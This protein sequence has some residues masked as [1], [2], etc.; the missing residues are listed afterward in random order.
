MI[1]VLTCDIRCQSRLDHTY[2]LPAKG[3]AF[4]LGSGCLEEILVQVLTENTTVL[5]MSCAR[6]FSA[7][8]NTVPLAVAELSSG[9]RVP[10]MCLGNLWPM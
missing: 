9:Q 6:H 1:T 4:T 8:V 2:G 7:N 5:D 10:T 3:A